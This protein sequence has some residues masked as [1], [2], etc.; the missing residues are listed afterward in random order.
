MYHLTVSRGQAIIVFIQ[1]YQTEPTSTGYVLAAMMCVASF[2][3]A[4]G[5]AHSYQRVGLLVFVSCFLPFYSHVIVSTRICCYSY[6]LC[7][8]AA[9]VKAAVSA[10][11]SDR[12]QQ[13]G[14]LRVFRECHC[15]SRMGPGGGGGAGAVCGADGEGGAEH[16]GV[17]QGDTALQ[18]RPPGA[19]AE[20]R[21]EWAGRSSGRGAWSV[22]RGERI[23][24]VSPRRAGARPTCASCSV[25]ANRDGPGAT[26]RPTLGRAHK[27]M[28]RRRR[29]AAAGGGGGRGGGGQER[30]TG[31]IVNLMS[32]DAERMFQ[33]PDPAW[34]CRPGS[35]MP[36]RPWN[37]TRGGPG[38]CGRDLHPRRLEG[39]CGRISPVGLPVRQSR[40][41]RGVRAAAL[42]GA[43]VP[44]VGSAPRRVRQPADVHVHVHVHPLPATRPWRAG[45]TGCGP[46]LRRAR[47]SVGCD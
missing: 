42:L 13:R 32:T 40:Q 6:C 46:R 12:S 30:T 5:K 35:G 34:E 15:A 7:C 45:S 39:R 9:T 29:P 16:G 22:G 14:C 44:R 18:R 4:L 47:A 43:C 2:F 10:C 24:L 20:A 38:R 21:R 19:P 25:L 1:N 11:S 41:A 37:A 23:R 36:A 31:E 26:L 8:P 17:P 28:R 3:V 27:R 33:V